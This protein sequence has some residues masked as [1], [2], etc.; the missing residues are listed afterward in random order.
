LVARYP[1]VAGRSRAMADD[2][3]LVAA[4]DDHSLLYGSDAASGRLGFLTASAQSRSFADMRSGHGTAAAFQN[5]DLTDDLTDVLSRLRSHGLDVIVVAQTTPEHRSGG[6][7]CV[8]VIV[9]GTLP[10]TFGHDYRRIHG[11]PRLFDVP[12]LLGYRDQALSPQD[13]NPHPHPFP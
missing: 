9:P 4:M 11:L 8:K 1:D 12:R 5:A 7:S 2:P 13:V 6:F 10:M 3:S